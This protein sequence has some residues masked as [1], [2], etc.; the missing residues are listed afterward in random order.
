M[1]TQTA[2]L[3]RVAR[4]ARVVLLVLLDLAGL[5]TSTAFAQSQTVM[6]TRAT[7]LRA[8]KLGSAAIVQPL[9]SG[10][11]LRVISVEGAWV[12]VETGAPP[13]VSGWVRASAVNLQTA[14]SAVSGL[15]S[16]REA[17]GNTAAT[18]G[19][20]SLP[21]RV[22]RHALIIGIS[23]YADAATPPLPGARCTVHGLTN[24]LP[25]KWRRR[26]KCRRAI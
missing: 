22:N 17:S 2:F 16:G 6:T 3:S 14:A 20:R 9:A 4:M 24:S 5:G 1:T 11:A 10:A 12:L 13:Y 26:C 21:A 23:R 25:R 19:V 15:A 7:E 8:D 18:L